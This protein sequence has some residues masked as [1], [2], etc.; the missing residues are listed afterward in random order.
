MRHPPEHPNGIRCIQVGCGPHHIREDWWNVDIRSFPGI[1]EAMD[2]TAPWRWKGIINYIYGEHFLEHLSLKGALS[3]LL[4]SG[5][6]LRVGGKIRLSTPSLEWVLASHF[7]ISGS[8]DQITQDTLRI[9]RAF[10]GW[11]HQF[12]YSRAMLKRVLWSIGF[13]D[14]K[15]FE[16]GYSD[17]PF[18][19]NLERHRNHRSVGGFQ[20]VHIVEASRGHGDIKVSEELSALLEREYLRHIESGH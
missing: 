12:L 11:G 7:D 1:D 9:N 6:A 4:Q 14:I 16:Y 19:R 2:V 8:E 10:H 3:F 18:L 13:I 17:D 5:E 15:F 20:S